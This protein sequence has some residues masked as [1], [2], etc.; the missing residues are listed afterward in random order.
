[1]NI[2]TIDIVLITTILHDNEIDERKHKIYR[3]TL[4]TKYEELLIS[5]INLFSTTG[6]G[7]KDSHV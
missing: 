4:L 6:Y 2:K 5:I 7:Y 1:M 3:I